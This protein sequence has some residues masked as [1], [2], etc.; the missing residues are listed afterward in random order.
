MELFQED[1]RREVFFGDIR[2]KVRED[3][4]IFLRLLREERIGDLIRT[5]KNL[6]PSPESDAWK[7]GRDILTILIQELHIHAVLSGSFTEELL[8]DVRTSSELLHSNSD[9]EV[10]VQVFA[11]KLRDYVGQSIKPSVP[12][13]IQKVLAYVQDRYAEPKFPTDF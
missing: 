6:F 5:I 8:S 9:L 10:F 3:F 11:E 2:R 7:A 12:V 1:V 13:I 4:P